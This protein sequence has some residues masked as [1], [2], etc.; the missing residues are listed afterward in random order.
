M[1]T[2]TNT[3]N[4]S[5]TPLNIV[6]GQ[7]TG[8]CDSKCDYSFKYQSSSVNITNKGSYI[9]ISYDTGNE[10][11]VKYNQRSYNVTEVRIYFPSAHAYMGKQAPG[12]IVIIHTPV[13]GG[14]NLIVSV[15]VR[16]DQT[17]T[18]SKGSLII[19]SIIQGTARL[20]PKKGETAT[21]NIVQAGAPEFSLNEIVPY[22]PFYSYTGPDTFY[23]CSQTVDY[24]I[25]TPL[26]SNISIEQDYLNR[27]QKIITPSGITAKQ[28]SQSMPLFINENGPSKGNA[29]EG[30]YIDCQPV[31]QSEE[32]E[33]VITNTNYDQS[34]VDLSDLL[35]SN[36]FRFIGISILMIIIILIV[37]ALFKGFG[38]KS[39]AKNTVIPFGLMTSKT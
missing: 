7:Q 31:G 30:I 9:S 8:K 6:V 14:N 26:A 17:A 2:L 12:E 4:S 34:P 20:A 36:W 29:N 1:T 3:C 16:P 25:F 13:S 39:V 38:P 24:I 18:T 15:P 35:N 5:T 32:T 27:I 10:S 33:D 21:V 37:S 23:N 22:K 11:P 28:S 19:K